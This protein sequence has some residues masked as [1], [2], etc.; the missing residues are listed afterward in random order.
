V[1]AVGGVRFRALAADKLGSDHPGAVVE[2]ALVVG[3]GAYAGR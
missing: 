3:L 2:D 1:G